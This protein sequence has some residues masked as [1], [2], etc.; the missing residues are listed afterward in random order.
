MKT[1]KMSTSISI[2]AGELIQADYRASL[3][4]SSKAGLHIFW[5]MVSGAKEYLAGDPSPHGSVSGRQ[6]QLG[7][8]NHPDQCSQWLGDSAHY[9]SGEQP[10]HLCGGPHHMRYRRRANA[11]GLAPRQAGP[12]RDDESGRWVA[13]EHQRDAQCRAKKCAEEAVCVW[14]SPRAAATCSAKS[15]RRC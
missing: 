2:S 10:E 6:E 14:T 15:H 5:A 3:V 13:R 12:M 11:G 9:V 4:G 1:L 8:A 7:L